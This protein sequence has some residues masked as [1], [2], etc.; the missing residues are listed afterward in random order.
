[1]E[2]HNQIFSPSFKHELLCA[3][4]LKTSRVLNHMQTSAM[5]EYPNQPRNYRL[6]SYK[7]IKGNRLATYVASYL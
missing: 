4:L 1:M 6:L 3:L 2:T 7:F 5:G